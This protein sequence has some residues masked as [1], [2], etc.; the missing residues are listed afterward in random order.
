MSFSA[1]DLEK[2]VDAARR[3]VGLTSDDNADK[4]RWMADLNV[5][6]VCLFEQNRTQHNFD[7][8]LGCYRT[9]AGLPLGLPVKRLASAKKHVC[10]LTENVGFCS[11]E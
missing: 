7:E 11:L 3:A 9:I 1:I 6:L 4:L 2:A 10:F 5:Y 8:A